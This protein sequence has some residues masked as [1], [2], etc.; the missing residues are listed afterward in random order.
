ML[1]KNE[2]ERSEKEKIPDI[3]FGRASNQYVRLSHGPKLKLG[4]VSMKP[5]VTDQKYP[6]LAC[7]YKRFEAMIETLE[8]RLDSA[9]LP[10][11]VSKGITFVKGLSKGYSR[12]RTQRRELGAIPFANVADAYAA[13]RR[14]RPTVVN[15]DRSKG[16]DSSAMAFATSSAMAFATTNTSDRQQTEKRQCHICK[17]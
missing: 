3:R 14:V 2:Q 16:D 9:Q 15:N 6:E 13:A 4:T 1:C 5:I 10:N 12:W 7:Y 11:D 17:Q 8:S